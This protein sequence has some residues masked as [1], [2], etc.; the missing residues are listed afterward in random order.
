MKALILIKLGVEDFVSLL[1][2]IL[3][4]LIGV[5]TGMMAWNVYGNL[6]G[7]IL[8]GFFWPVGLAWM[9][10]DHTLTQ[11]LVKTTFGFLQK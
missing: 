10:V 7:A 3:Y 9:L 5:G 4:L 2:V 1:L 8:A 6:P 11:T